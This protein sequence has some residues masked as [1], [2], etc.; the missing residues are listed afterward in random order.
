MSASVCHIYVDVLQHNCKEF[1]NICKISARSLQTFCRYVNCL[2]IYLQNICIKYA[3]ICRYV[4]CLS[5]YLQNICIKFAD[6]CRYVICLSKYLQNICIKYADI[7]RYVNCLSIYLQNICKNMQIF[8]D[9][10]FVCH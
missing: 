10:S 3:D 2:S 4:N 8:A 9:M 6:I 1:D 7:G 5:K